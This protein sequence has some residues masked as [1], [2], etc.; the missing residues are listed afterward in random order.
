MVMLGVHAPVA[1]KAPPF[2]CQSI[3]AEA[4][5]KGAGCPMSGIFL[6][7][8]VDFFLPEIAYA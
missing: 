8:T 2:K 4:S 5:R 6:K 7:A 1:F 3:L